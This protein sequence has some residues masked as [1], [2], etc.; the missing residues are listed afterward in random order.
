M[1]ELFDGGN[2]SLRSLKFIFGIV[3]ILAS[4]KM[5]QIYHSQ[6]HLPR[7][8]FWYM[9]KSTYA[10]CRAIIIY[11]GTSFFRQTAWQ[12]YKRQRGT[13]VLFDCENFDTVPII[14]SPFERA[15]LS[16][17]QLTTVFTRQAFLPSSID[18]QSNSLKVFINGIALQN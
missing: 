7:D 14:F 5:G 4:E 6:S 12:A 16:L 17:R 10:D 8:F 2:K 15:F 3:S 11:F 1:V 18:Y 9:C 13:F